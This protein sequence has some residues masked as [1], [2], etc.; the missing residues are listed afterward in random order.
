MYQNRLLSFIRVINP[1]G[2]YKYCFLIFKV[3]HQN[4]KQAGLSFRNYIQKLTS[5]LITLINNISF[6]KNV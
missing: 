3:N 6:C 4:V 5:K 2:L 1:K